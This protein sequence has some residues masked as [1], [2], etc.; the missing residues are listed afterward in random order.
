LGCELIQIETVFKHWYN[1]ISK[2][3]VMV[4]KKHQQES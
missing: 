3:T 1:R 4:T 2:T